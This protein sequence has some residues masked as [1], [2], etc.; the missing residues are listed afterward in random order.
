M[1]A[2]TDQHRPATLIT[3]NYSMGVTFDNR[4]GTEWPPTEH[5][6][7]VLQMAREAAAT[8][9]VG[10]GI[11]QCHHCGASIRYGA[12]LHH[13]SGESIIVG[14]TCLDRFGLSSS[15]FHTMRKAAELDRARHAIRQAIAAFSAANPDLAWLGEKVTPEPHAANGFL[16]DVARKLRTYGSLSDRQIDAV[17]KAVIRDAERVARQAAEALEPTVPVPTGRV[18]IA[19]TIVATKWQDSDYG[20]SLKM[21]I[22]VETPAGSFKLWGSVPK[23]LDAQMGDAVTLKATIEPSERDESFGFMKRPTL[24]AGKRHLVVDS[25]GEY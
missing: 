22:R 18:V 8:S 6:V 3:E 5:Q 17:R 23:G 10:R 19:G 25:S 21:L 11:H 15:E 1:G 4:V 9:S 12:V 14:E 16:V 24:V 13:V 2:R 20:G 7:R